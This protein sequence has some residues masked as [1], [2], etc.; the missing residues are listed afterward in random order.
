ML[1][2]TA[3][4]AGVLFVAE[5]IPHFGV[6]IELVGG[7]LV[8]PFIFVFPPLFHILIKVQLRLGVFRIVLIAATLY[9]VL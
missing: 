8:T 5:S 9:V 2:R 1:L 4:M 7:L 3:V 6:A